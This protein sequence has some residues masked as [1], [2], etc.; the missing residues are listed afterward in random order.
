MNR[1]TKWR[2]LALLLALGFVL[3]AVVPSVNS[4]VPTT[5]PTN[6]FDYDSYLQSLMDQAPDFTNSTQ[7]SAP[8]GIAPPDVNV[9]SIETVTDLVLNA[10]SLV[11]TLASGAP[12]PNAQLILQCVPPLDPLS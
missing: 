5:D 7:D 6:C 8:V 11:A 2:Y 4:Q 3:V 1:N 9:P 10:S 12:V